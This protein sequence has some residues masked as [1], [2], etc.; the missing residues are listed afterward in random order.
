M[1][2]PSANVLTQV[3]PPGQAPWAFGYEYGAEPNPG[4]A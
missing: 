4:S 2:V 3:V 1:T